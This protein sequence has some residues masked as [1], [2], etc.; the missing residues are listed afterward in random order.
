MWGDN[1][2]TNGTGVIGAGNDTGATVLIA[3]SGGAFN[4]S[5]TGLAAFSD[6]TGVGQA[7]YAQQLTDPVRVGFWNGTTFFKINGVGTVST[8]VKD[9][10]D[11]AG[12]R[13][14]TLHAPEAPEIYF[15][16]FGTG[17]LVNGRARVDL[18]P[19]LLGNVAIDAAHPMRVF[20][21]LEEDENTRGVVVKNKTATGFDVV[22]IQGGR[23]NLPFQWQL[24]VNRADEV[25]PSGRVSRN[26]DV[27]FQEAAPA[28]A[29][30]GDAGAEGKRRTNMP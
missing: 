12:E 20:I 13:R 6:T 30:E 24:V 22:E 23:S 2:N 21:Q 8:H 28:A 29:T 25:L 19:R 15:M 16:D 26:A 3:G 1:F 11:P 10:T 14:V 27:R 7:I 4:G 18:D 17:K 5:I 9:P